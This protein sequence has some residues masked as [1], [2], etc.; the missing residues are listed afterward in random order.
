MGI[1]LKGLSKITGYSAITISR[2]L[3]KP[4]LVKEKTREKILYA[5]NKYHYSPNNVAKALVYNRT[6][7]IYLYVSYNL[8]PTNQFVLQVSAGISGYLGEHGYSV[9]LSKKWYNHEAVDGLILMGL[10]LEDEQ[11]LKSLAL[12][13]PLV[14]F[15]HSENVDCIDVDNIKGMEMITEYALAK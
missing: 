1:T 2:A 15:G 4:N 9:L 11:N 7:I 6:N 12:E 14:L 5:V 10:S 3:N 8:D 13:K